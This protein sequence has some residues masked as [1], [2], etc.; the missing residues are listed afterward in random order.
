[1]EFKSL[2]LPI[3]V[4]LALD[5]LRVQ[6]RFLVLIGVDGSRVGLPNQSSWHTIFVFHPHVRTWVTKA[7][8]L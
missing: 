2:L 1:M 8:F 5:V 7:A 6:S 4:H 3:I